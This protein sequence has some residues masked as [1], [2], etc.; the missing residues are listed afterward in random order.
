MKRSLTFLSVIM[1]FL[2]LSAADMRYVDALGLT[3]A[4]PCAASGYRICPSG[5]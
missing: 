2:G 5:G 1:L 4:E 3:V